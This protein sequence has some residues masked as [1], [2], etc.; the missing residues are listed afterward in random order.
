METP[1]SISETGRFYD[2]SS[3]SGINVPCSTRVKG[4]E[5][6]EGDERGNKTPYSISETGTFY[7]DSSESGKNAP[8]STRV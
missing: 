2:D 4:G 7:D 5:D 8:C 1:Y 6:E 3:D